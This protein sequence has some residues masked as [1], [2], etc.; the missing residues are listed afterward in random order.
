LIFLFVADTSA[1]RPANPAQAQALADELEGLGRRLLSI[2]QARAR[3]Q[4]I[5]ADTAVRRGAV[6]Q[7][8][9]DFLREVQASVLVLGAPGTSS[10]RNAF[11]LGESSQVTQNIHAS[12]GVEVIVV[13]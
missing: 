6:W 11:G 3:E 7:A 12:T 4:G 2:A 10:E 8:I 13:E 5:A 9:E 1:I